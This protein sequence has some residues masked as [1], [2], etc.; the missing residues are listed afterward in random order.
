MTPCNSRALTRHEGKPLS[1]AVITEAQLRG[2]LSQ[3]G[4]PPFVIDAVAEVKRTFVRGY[5][6][7][8]TSDIERLSGRA[9]KLF[10]DVV[11]AVLSEGGNQ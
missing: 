6:D 8:L 1:Y 9:P 11:R 5:F 7:I 10:R 4:L 2:G 3:A